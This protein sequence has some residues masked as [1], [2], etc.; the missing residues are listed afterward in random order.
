MSKLEVLVTTMHQSDF[1]KFYQM[2]L[3]TN[4]VIANQTD[5]NEYVEANINGHRVKMVST[6]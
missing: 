5:K 1:S 4:A 2:N 3:Q 6:N